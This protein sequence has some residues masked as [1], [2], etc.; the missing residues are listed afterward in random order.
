LLIG[1][2]EL[3]SG[4]AG[5]AYQIMLDAARRT[6]DEPLFRRATEIALQARAGEQALAATRAWRTARPESMDALRLQLQI[7]LSMNR[8]RGPAE[9]LRALI[10]GTPEAERAASSARCRV[11]CS[12]PPTSGGWPRCSKTCCSPT[13]PLR[14]AR[15][16]AGGHR[17]RL[18]GRGRRRAVR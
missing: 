4:Q 2:I 15:G 13:C 18:A 6:R 12:A 8:M 3:R 5:N 11:S 17:P 10:A 1:E 7:L 16:C 9:P 14:H